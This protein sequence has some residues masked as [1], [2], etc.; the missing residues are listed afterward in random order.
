LKNALAYYTAGVVVVNSEVVGSTYT[1]RVVISI[2]ADEK[3]FP[4]RR[5]LMAEGIKI[6]HESCETT[7]REVWA[8]R[9][10]VSCQKIL[11]KCL[12]LELGSILSF[13]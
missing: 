3:W 2:D 1:F 13:L 11:K 7:T 6:F 4:S 9:D 8:E 12:K 10:D 5:F